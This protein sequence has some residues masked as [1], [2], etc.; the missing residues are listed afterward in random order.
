M[1]ATVESG[2][3]RVVGRLG[4]VEFIDQIIFMPKTFEP[5]FI[6]LQK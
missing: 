6:F 4:G 1:G 5:F 2:K 3:I